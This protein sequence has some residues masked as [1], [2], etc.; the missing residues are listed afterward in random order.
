M[1][2]NKKGYARKNLMVSSASIRE[3]RRL[4]DADSESEAVRIA[5]EDRLLA[6][7]LAAATDR[8]AGHGGL[9][10]VFQR[11]S[12]RPVKSRL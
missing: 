1:G 4:L 2:R 8:I 12:R 6:E 3:L 10:D 9:L 11:T 7:K 5:I